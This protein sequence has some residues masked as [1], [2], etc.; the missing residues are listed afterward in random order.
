MEQEK[1]TQFAMAAV[2]FASLFN[3][4]FGET[5]VGVFR[6]E[7]TA[8]EG[9]ST[10]GGKQALQ[11]IKLSQASGTIVVGSANTVERTCEL[12]PYEQVAQAY[13]QRFGSAFPLEQTAFDG[14]IGRFRGFFAS[15]AYQVTTRTAPAP[16][17]PS[18]QAQ[19]APKGSPVLLIAAIA[20]GLVAAALAVYF[21][22]LKPPA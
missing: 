22:F 13:E 18:A 21:L 6:I 7:L 11:H 19:P 4:T 1:R 8:P 3:T 9:Q 14:L 17:R 16:A 20:V 10:G 5:P 2:D 12:R 15:Q